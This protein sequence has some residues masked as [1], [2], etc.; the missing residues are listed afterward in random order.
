MTKEETKG[1]EA[2]PSLPAGAGR[3]QPAVNPWFWRRESYVVD[4]GCPSGDLGA[5]GVDEPLH[6]G[7]D[8]RTVGGVTG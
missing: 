8:H 6:E 4:D 5:V 7:K 3:R 2:H 1:R